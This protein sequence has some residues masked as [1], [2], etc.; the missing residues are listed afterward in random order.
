MTG[1]HAGPLWRFLGRWAP[2]LGTPGVLKAVVLLN[3]LTFILLSAVP[4]YRD[5]LELSPEAVRHGEVWRLV[6]YI[7]IP[8]ASGWFWVAL[9]LLFMLFLANGLEEAWGP[10][11]LNA[12]YLLG[13]IGCTAAAFFFQGASYNTFLNLSLFFAFATLAPDYEIYL[14][15]LLRVKI[16][17]VAWF[18]AGIML[19]QFAALPPSGKMAMLACLANYLIFFVPGFVQRARMR[20][21]SAVRLEKFRA[22]IA[23]T[24][25]CCAVCKCTEVSSPE[26]DFRVAADGEEY[27]TKHL[28]ERD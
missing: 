25:H 27:C 24:L 11:R 19:L 1:D 2:W 16:K 28:P 3:A 22:D 18:F 15:F 5:V 23:D 12:F 20:R 13:M 17:Y 14:F 4:A 10:M 7:F 9:Y 26:A 6:T 8:Q 21:V